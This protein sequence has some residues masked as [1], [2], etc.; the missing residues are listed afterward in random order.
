MSKKKLSDRDIEAALTYEEI[1]SDT[2]SYAGGD[3]SDTEDQ[4]EIEK[5]ANALREGQV[6]V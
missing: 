2:D 1:P 6:E 3:S 4:S 5:G